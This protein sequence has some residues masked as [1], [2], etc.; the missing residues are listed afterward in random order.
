MDFE[1]TNSIPIF[2]IL[3]VLLTLV[4]ALSIFFD[5]HKK[6]NLKKSLYF[7]LFMTGG[8]LLGTLLLDSIGL[9]SVIAVPFLL[10]AFLFLSKTKHSQKEPL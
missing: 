7:I 9:Y 2:K 5:Y 3:F 6:K 4:V 10:V 8:I 1:P